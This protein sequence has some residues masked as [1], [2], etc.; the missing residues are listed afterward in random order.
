MFSVMIVR[1]GVKGCRTGRCLSRSIVFSA[2]I[3]VASGDYEAESACLQRLVHRDKTR[4]YLCSVPLNICS[5]HIL[6]S[7]Y[8]GLIVMRDNIDKGGQAFDRTG[9]CGNSLN[10]STLL[11]SRQACSLKCYLAVWSLR[12][13]GR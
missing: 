13:C 9:R 4:L 5:G 11:T 3:S 8:T 6:A 1:A 12:R 10:P 7:L 2:S